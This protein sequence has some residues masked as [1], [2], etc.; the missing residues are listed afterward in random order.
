MLD[1]I[2]IPADIAGEE[3]I[4]MLSELKTQGVLSA[5]QACVLAFWAAKAG[6]CGEVH[7]M[8]VR[9]NQESAGT[10]SD[11]TSGPASVS[12]R[13]AAILYGWGGGCAMWLVG[14]GARCL[15]SCHTKH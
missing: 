2:T 14:S 10:P 6:A 8:A 1:Y 13:R 5:K 7:N 4:H 11:L 3:L 15:P 12:T 9:P